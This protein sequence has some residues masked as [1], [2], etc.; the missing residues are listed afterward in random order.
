MN[1]ELKILYN[2]KQKR[3]DREG[4]VREEADLNQ[5]LKS[6]LCTIKKKRWVGVEEGLGRI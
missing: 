5:E 1:H 3:G 4:R 2:L 6:V